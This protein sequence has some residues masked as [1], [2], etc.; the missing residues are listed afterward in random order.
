MIPK[1]IEFNV[2][3]WVISI[4]LK[5]VFDRIEHRALSQALREQEVDVGLVKFTGD[6][7]Q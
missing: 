2:P 5:R 6:F 1:G 7:I 3:V 4:D